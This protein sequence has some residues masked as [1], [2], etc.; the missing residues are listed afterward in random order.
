MM[1]AFILAGIVAVATIVIVVMMFMA[2]SM[3]DN[4]SMADDV[5]HNAIYLLFIGIALA[6]MI[7]ASHWLPHIGW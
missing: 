2:A 5:G 4:S 1:A 6:V 3:S 7:A